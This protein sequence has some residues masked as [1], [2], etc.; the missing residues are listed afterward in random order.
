MLKFEIIKQQNSLKA[1]NNFEHVA[2]LFSLLANSKHRDKRKSPY[3]SMFQ[4]IAHIVSI[5]LLS[6]LNIFLPHNSERNI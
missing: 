2:L 6:T 5:S 4:K 1:D 3:I